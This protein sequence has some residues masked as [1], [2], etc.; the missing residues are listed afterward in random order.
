MPLRPHQLPEEPCQ[1]NSWQTHSLF[2]AEL[3][4]D[5]GPWRNIDEL[6][7]EVAGYID[8]FNHRR[9]HGEI[10]LVPRAEHEAACH[11]DHAVPAPAET[12]LAS[13]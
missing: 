2:K 4:R 3:I 6:E 7:I 10:G 13:L 11:R 9:L 1:L 12:A 8:W 5:R